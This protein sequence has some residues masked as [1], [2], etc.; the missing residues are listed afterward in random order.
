MPSSSGALS[1]GPSDFSRVNI[2]GAMS[3]RASKQV[4]ISTVNDTSEEESETFTVSMAAVTTGASPT[5]SEIVLGNPSTRTVTIEANDEHLV[6]NVTMGSIGEHSAAATIELD[7]PSGSNRTVYLRYR[8]RPSGAWS[9]PPLMEDTPG[10]SV[11]VTLDM[12]DSNTP[13]QV[14][15]SLVMDFWEDV[16]PPTFSTLS[17]DPTVSGI[18]FED[19]EQTEATA[20]IA[21]ANL[22]GSE[23][24]VR[25]RYRT[26]PSTGS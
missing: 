2:G 13:Y 19:V 15:A 26:P 5:D 1:F 4:T 10:T 3:Y 20:L 21:M 11:E 6:T 25:L 17:G 18:T 9:D 16:E 22:D 24:T 23:Q 14:Q 8:K 7:N 12:L